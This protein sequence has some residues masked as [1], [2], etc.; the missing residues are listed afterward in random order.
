MLSCGQ[1][2]S[3]CHL[4]S[5]EVNLLRNALWPPNLVG[6]TPDQSVMHCWG[7]RSC[8][9][10]RGQPEVKLLRNT[11]WP[12]NL[13]GRTPDQSVMHCWG[14]RSCKGQPGV[15]QRSN[16]LEMPYG[17]QIWSEELTR[18]KCIAGIK[19][20]AGVKQGHPEVKLLGNPQWPPT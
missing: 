9:V 2:S 5:I 19:G 10:S 11:L 18:A 16:C 12:P 1:S 14:Q 20:Q 4:E 3:R 13:V 6:R 8:S 15:N 7:Q 17:N